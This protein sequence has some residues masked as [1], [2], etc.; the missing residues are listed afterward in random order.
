MR[1]ILFII[2]LAFIIN[3]C[4]DEKAPNTT[5]PVIVTITPPPSTESVELAVSIGST[6]C[7]NDGTPLA[8]W[9]R[10]LTASG[11]E[12]RASSCG[13]DG[14]GYA[15]VCGGSDGRIAIVEV[16]SSQASTASIF[17]FFP[18]SKL[19]DATKTSCR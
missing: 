2:C 14:R 12:V 8:E 18:L 7:M 15:S 9:V 13:A 10:R 16:P 11:V 3:G 6:Q 19:P 5:D 1:R 4:G 17:G